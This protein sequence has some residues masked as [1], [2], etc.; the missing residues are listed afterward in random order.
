MGRDYTIT[1]GNLA[2]QSRK[3]SCVSKED[4]K[5]TLMWEET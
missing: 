5:E 4:K 2:F 1:E 3:E